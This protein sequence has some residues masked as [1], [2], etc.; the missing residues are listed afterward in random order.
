[1]KS[2]MVFFLFV[3]L[4]AFFKSQQFHY[5]LSICDLKHAHDEQLSDSIHYAQI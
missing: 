5:D 1:M 2:A 3:L 4:P